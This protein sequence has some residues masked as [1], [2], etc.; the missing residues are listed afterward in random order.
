MTTIEG[1]DRRARHPSQ[2]AWIEARRRRSAA[3][4]SPAR[5]CA[6]GVARGEA[7]ADRRRH[8]RGH[9]RQPLPLRHLPADPRGDPRAAADA[10]ERSDEPPAACLAPRLPPRSAAVG[11]GLVLGFHLAGRRAA[12]RHDR[13]RRAA[14]RA[15]TRSSASRPTTRDGHRQHSPRWA[16][17]SYTVAADGRRRG[18]G[19]R[20]DKVRFEPAP[21]RCGLRAHFLRHAR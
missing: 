14:A 3:T 11:G 5:S 9:G 12:R 17:A 2:R 18:A 1:L 13:A 10:G 16:R 8:R 19:G 20:L 6:A 15:R 4:A 7:Q 21:G